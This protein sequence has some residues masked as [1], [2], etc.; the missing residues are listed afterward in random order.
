[1]VEVVLL[2]HEVGDED[3]EPAIVVVIA[4]VH[5]HGAFG[6]SFGAQGRAG[7]HADVGKRAIVIVM[8]KII[9]A[10]VIR[11]VEI[12]PAV[13]VIVA[14]DD[15]E[16]VV[17]VGVVHAG[18]LRDF[19][20]CSVATIVIEQVGFSE[21]APGTALHDDAAEFATA[22]R[23]DVGE[24]DVNVPGDKNI[25]EAVPIIIR[26]CSA[27]HETAAAH[28]GF[29]GDIFKSA[30]TAVAVESIAAV[31]GDEYVGQSIVVKI[32]DG[33]AHAPTLAGQPCL[34]GYVFKFQRGGLPVEGDHGVA[35]LVVA[36]DGRTI[37]NEGRER[38][39]VIAVDEADAT[40][41]RFDDVLFLGRGNVRNSEARAC[42][43]F[44]EERDGGA[45][46]ASLRATDDT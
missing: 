13:V 44:L 18:F 10:G 43:Y 22:E 7:L 24:V 45:R 29:V 41:H 40:A 31:A 11:D 25:D 32:G 27:G 30:I 16:T 6:I 26:P 12:G 19:F 33:N 3:V 5:A 8:V 17:G 20:K 4:K 28:S 15:A 39:A 34:L 9:R 38:A 14:P 2:V 1:V 23:S 36:I 21:H 42:R 35:A 46:S 37:D